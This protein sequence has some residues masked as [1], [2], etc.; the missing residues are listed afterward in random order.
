MESRARLR[1]VA[2]RLVGDPLMDWYVNELGP[3]VMVHEP[4][5]FGSAYIRG[6]EDLVF[7]ARSE[8]TDHVSGAS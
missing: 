2:D 3:G 1:F 5:H 4:K 7:V 6:L 8:A